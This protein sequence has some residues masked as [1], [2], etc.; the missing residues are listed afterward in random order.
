MS[1]EIQ[2]ERSEQAAG[3]PAVEELAYINQYAKTPLEAQQVYAFAV[4][5]CDNEVDRDYERFA[6]AGLTRLGELFL[7]KSGIFDHQWSAK[8]Q[9]A[10]IY[11]TEVVAEP[12]RMTAAGDGYCYLKGWAYLLRT[13]GNAELIAE[14]EGGI[15]K[16]VSVGCSVAESV[17]SV[18]GAPAGTCHHVKGEI[19]DGKLCFTELRE[20]TDAY[21]WSFVAVPAQR[22]AGVLKRYGGA[23]RERIALERE[24]ALGRRYMKSLRREVA[25]LAMLADETVPGEVWSSVVEKLEEP[26]LQA[27]KC[28]YERMAAKRFPPQPQLR[29]ISAGPAED[30]TVFLV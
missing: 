7:G 27:L 23:D 5:L 8:G 20:P 17:C 26:E 30:E 10:R 11:R 13:E 16:E 28:A 19:Y 9:T 6:T 1:V 4:R 25:R 12:G 22:D 15:K 14:I 21:E 3:T 18:C 24:A 2:K 29:G